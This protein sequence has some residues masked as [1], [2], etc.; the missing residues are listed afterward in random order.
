MFTGLSAYTFLV[1]CS[2]L[3]R[4]KKETSF[5]L[6]S[7]MILILLASGFHLYPLHGRLILFLAPILFLF[8]A[9]GTEQLRQKTKKKSKFSGVI[10]LVLLFFYPALNTYEI[11]R[12]PKTREEIK[13]VISYL[14]EYQKK[15]DILYIYYGA[16]TA[17]K[18]YAERYN[19]KEGEY[20]LGRKYRWNFEIFKE[21][22]DTLR[23]NKRVWILFSHIY[24]DE[25][26][27]SIQY[28]DTI[29]RKK[30]YK[31][32]KGA[33]VYLYKLK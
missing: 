14:K 13:S 11:I 19:F 29:G 30:A 18:Y 9:E 16:S 8:V 6:L 31:K 24:K 33:S 2:L 25:E 10:L 5:L 28:L 21:D 7:P 22:L 23:G 4:E 3:F 20:V 12:K 15:Q 1:G 32:A 27:L 26:K 17:F